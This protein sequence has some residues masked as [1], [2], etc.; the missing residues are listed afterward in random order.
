MGLAKVSPSRSTFLVPLLVLG[1]ILFQ[2]MPKEQTR[3]EPPKAAPRLQVQADFPGG[4][5]RVEAIDEETRT[6]QLV[7]T[8]HKDR[9]WVCWWYCKVIGIR[10]GET[11]ILDVGGGVWASPDRACFSLDNKQWRH[12]EPGNR[13]KERIVYHQ[14]VDAE[15]AW[16]A[17]GPPF[18]LQHAKVLV[19]QAV[20][21]NPHTKPFELGKSTE[22][23]RVPGLRIEQ[24]GVPDKDRL[25][26]WVQARQHAWESGSS[27]VCR[28][29]TD[30]LLSDDPRAVSL[31]QKATITIVP[32][33]DV[34]NVERGAGGKNQKPHDHNRD[35]G[36]QP[37]WPE[38]QEA[39][40][41][42]TALNQAARFDLFVD[43]HN[44]G[45]GDRQPFF[46]V[47]PVEVLSVHGRHNLNV[48]LDAARREITGPLKLGDKARESGMKYD[49]NWQRISGNWV[50]RHTRGHVVGVCLE[51]AWNTPQ[52]T[53][54]NYQRVGKELG[55]AVERYLRE[56]IRA[57]E[58]GK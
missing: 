12:T 38:V 28:G 23:R 30:W 14:R 34:D 1:C 57:R 53:Q 8:P 52:S 55:L 44:P 7:P 18:V 50:V 51:T 21:K 16:F 37:V 2:L 27:W 10:P 29:F 26:I 15:E 41:Q 54:E 9:G 49:P 13:S 24:P 40:K 3:A 43:L 46:F 47:P 39:M 35:W 36:E 5:A 56:P 25:G 20:K 42:I 17:W 19:E 33:M 58:T 48:F 45:P 31:R 6:I 11:I 32:I 4:S 22:G